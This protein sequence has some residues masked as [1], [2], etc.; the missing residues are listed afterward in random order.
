M[1]MAAR[2]ENA[3]TGRVCRLYSL[4]AERLESR[5][6]LAGDP[7]VAITGPAESL[8]GSA[9]TLELGAVDLPAPI[10]GW[11][12]DWGDLF[13]LNY[14][15]DITQAVHQYADNGNYTVKATARAGDQEYTSNE[16]LVAVANVPPPLNISG[17]ATALMGQTYRISLYATDVGRDA[18]VEWTINWGNG[19][20]TRRPGSSTAGYFTYTQP[21]TYTI[22]ATAYDEDGTYT[23]N[24]M[25]VKVVDPTPR[26]MLTATMNTVVAGQPV[27]FS[28]AMIDAVEPEKYDI[29][30]DFGDGTVRSWADAQSPGAMK[31]I[32]AFGKPGTYTV[33]LT[34][35][36][37][38]Y[39]TGLATTQVKVTG[40]VQQDRDLLIGCGGGND[41]VQVNAAAGGGIAVTV[42]GRNKGVFNAVNRVVVYGNGG[43]DRI[44]V[45]S[46][47]RLTAEL[48]GGAGNDVLSAGGKASILVGGAG[49]DSLSGSSGRDLLIGGRG[50]DRI[51][52]L[53]DQD[54]LV[55]GTT[56]YDEKPDQ[57]RLIFAE[58]G[59][60]VLSA[61]RASSSAAIV[62]MPTPQL[63]GGT[64][65]DDIAVD[66]LAGGDGSDVFYAGDRTQKDKLLDRLKG[67]R[68]VLVR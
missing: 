39:G 36:H 6:L 37:P 2:P 49:D 15:G 57:L 50:A 1:R 45:A 33:K 66:T 64:L 8:E 51:A 24:T 43:N 16:L 56:D 18:V 42:N 47:V 26:P 54:I 25:S 55:G 65:Q 14:D 7:Q 46:K 31:A 44:A 48:F 60:R 35:K 58:W 67:E 29:A 11:T 9:Y 59:S 40:L 41:D 38:V 68:V 5:C 23:A 10:T 21:G 3:R 53:G 30:W 17:P 32:R 19:R 13:V 61:Q 34:L 22:S 20:I 62:A 28:G 63:D 4:H 27:R 12:I 52:G